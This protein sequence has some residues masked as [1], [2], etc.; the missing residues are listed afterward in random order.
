MSSGVLA[1]WYLCQFDRAVIDECS[2]EHY[3][4]YVDD[5]IVVLNCVKRAKISDINSIVNE[6]FPGILSKVKKKSEGDDKTVYSVL[7]DQYKGL[8]QIQESKFKALVF[9]HKK[10]LALIE[11]FKEQVRK[12]SSEFRFL[13]EEDRL[14]EEFDEIA[15]ELNYQGSKNKLRSIEEF[16]NDLYSASVFLSKQIMREIHS[17]S[18]ASTSTARQILNFFSGRASI[19]RYQFWERVFTYFII[20]DDKK[21]FLKFIERIYGKLDLIIYHSEKEPSEKVRASYVSFLISTISLALAIKPSFIQNF[22]NRDL[23]KLSKFGIELAEL[24]EN[25]KSF[26]ESNLLRHR[27][28]EF[29]LLN[30]TNYLLDAEGFSDLVGQNSVRTNSYIRRGKFAIPRNRYLYSPRFVNFF[31]VTLYVI[32]KRLLTNRT[33]SIGPGLTY[34]RIQTDYLNEAFKIYYGLNYSRKRPGVGSVED[35]EHYEFKYEEFFCDCSP[36]KVQKSELLCHREIYTND[37]RK[38]ADLNIALANLKLS[39]KILEREHLQSPFIGNERKDAIYKI[40]NQVEKEKPKPDLVVLPEASIP[41]KWFNW[42]CYHASQR[43]QAMVFGLEHWLI[44]KK[45]Y[46]FNVSLLPVKTGLYK[47]LIINIRQKNHYS[48]KEA[49]ALEGLRFTIPKAEPCTYDIISWRGCIFTVFNCFELANVS[50]RASFRSI[51]DFIVACE[52]NKDTQYFSNIVES[53]SRDVH[54]YFI[55]SNNS[56]Y[57]D[58]RITQ[59]AKTEIRDILRLKGGDNKT[60]LTGEINIKELREFQVKLF[61]LQKDHPVFKPTPPEFNRDEVLK[62][63]SVQ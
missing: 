40:L 42:I 32:F 23:S 57:G 9:D 39:S 43:Q 22:K 38:K 7:E 56:E 50:H 30:Y 28:I 62:R 35:L 1:N 61:S 46:N 21:S 59:P 49:E 45:A 55:Q 60:I 44:D 4:R 63:I 14:P 41:R 25:I 8:I 51:V 16:N 10:P 47:S 33:N 5:I 11:Q 53:A 48:P 37:K 18:K 13:P 24:K 54:C 19:E 34:G 2:P 12:N 36:K 15:Y 17:D 3:G 52:F 6:Y 20:T 31:E 29:P 58:N 26:R 27:Y